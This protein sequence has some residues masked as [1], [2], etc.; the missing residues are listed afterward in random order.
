M[1]TSLFKLD[2]KGKERIWEV[3]VH[4]DSYTTYAGLVDGTLTSK[5]YTPTAKGKNTNAEQAQK[6]AQS[7]WNKKY[8]RELYRE[9]LSQPHP[10]AFIQPHH[11]LD[12]TKV[13]HRIRWG[14]ETYT[15]QP[16]LNGVRCIAQYVNG[17]IKLTS[18]KGKEYRV[19]HIQTQLLALYTLESAFNTPLDGELYI[20]GVELG[21][22]THSVSNNSRLLEYRI[23]DLVSDTRFEVRYEML[24]NLN[25]SFTPD[26]HLVPCEPIRNMEEVEEL[27]NIHVSDGYEGIMIRNINGVYAPNGRNEAMFKYKKFKDSEFRITDVTQ[28]SDGGAIFELRTK[29]GVPF[30]SRP[31]GTDAY[32]K[33]L[34]ENRSTIIHK[35]VTVRYSNLLASGV[36][37]F[38]RVLKGDGLIRDYE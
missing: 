34:W 27:H 31:M 37:E 32:R 2:S 5:T 14:A 21:D 29:D 3:E 38:N 1:L 35:F 17:K 22:V 36:P 8:A 10:L 13:P 11:A 19:D 24:Q 16:K 18:R 9:D 23:F 30:N 25:L 4:N 7:K 20:H 15:S 6:D 26:L 28:D 33:A 12:A